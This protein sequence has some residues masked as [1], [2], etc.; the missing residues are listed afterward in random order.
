M[1]GDVAGARRVLTDTP[2]LILEEFRYWD[3]H[4]PLAEAW[5]DAGDGVPTTA[6]RTVTVAA[7]RAR[8]FG[9]PAR[10]VL[11]LQTAAQFGDSSGADRLAE[12]SSIVQ[13]PRVGVASS[14]CA[15]LCH[16]DGD[17]LLA[18]SRAYE[19]FG[20]RVAAVDAAAQAAV[21]F[22]DRG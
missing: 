20:D 9:R 11:C 21:V 16:G 13:G 17:G 7:E 22:R 12:L 10:E 18:A 6:A 8:S 19:A 14:H 4:R 2:R 3:I 15:A 5:V 1:G